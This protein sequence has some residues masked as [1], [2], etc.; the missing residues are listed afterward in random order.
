MLNLDYVW[1]YFRGSGSS[2]Y[3]SQNRLSAYRYQYCL[4]IFK[5]SNW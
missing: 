5:K 2:I 1:M 4:R 3:L